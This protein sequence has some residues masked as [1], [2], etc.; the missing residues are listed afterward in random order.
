MK[1]LCTVYYLLQM[2]ISGV[3][4]RR[5]GEIVA[6]EVSI[7]LLQMVLAEKMLFSH[8]YKRL[9]KKINICSKVR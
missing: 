5:R 4:F 7:E 8:I 9:P 2:A 1:F 6:L 3:A